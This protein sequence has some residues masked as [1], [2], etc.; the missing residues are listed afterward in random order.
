MSLSKWT[1]GTNSTPAF[2]DEK[3][4]MLSGW[5]TSF[6]RTMVA[7]STFGRWRNSHR[8][9]W[10]LI[11]WW[12]PNNKGF[13]EAGNV[14]TPFAASGHCWEWRKS[15]PPRYPVGFPC[16]AALHACQ[17]ADSRARPNLLQQTLHFNK[18]PVWG[19]AWMV[20]KPSRESSFLLFSI[21]ITLSHIFFFNKYLFVFI[22]GC[23]GSSL[24]RTG[25][26]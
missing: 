3:S 9:L 6:H 13:K 4:K 21:W 5:L 12:S 10:A 26:L 2:V 7:H 22:F 19:V 11:L 14:L 8:A 15:P 23:V 17:K 24:L 18:L 25:F 16:R 1:E 20:R